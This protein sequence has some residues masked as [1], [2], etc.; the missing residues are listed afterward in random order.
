MI[1]TNQTNFVIHF[2]LQAQG[3][4]SEHKSVKKRV[5]GGGGQGNQKCAHA[6]NCLYL[7]VWCFETGTFVLVNIII[8]W[9]YRLTSA[10]SYHFLSLFAIYH[11]SAVAGQAYF[12]FVD[13]GYRYIDKWLG[14]PFIFSINFP[15]CIILFPS[16]KRG[17]RDTWEINN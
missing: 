13:K 8:K 9:C 17:V 7:S 10:W 11:Y 14:S 5:I 4:F 3:I 1:F 2:L 15:F 12:R 6:K 16:K